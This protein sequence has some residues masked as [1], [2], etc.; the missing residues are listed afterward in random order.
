MDCS[1]EAKASAAHDSLMRVK[2]RE[3]EYAQEALANGK[4]LQSAVQRLE[5][6]AHGLIHSSTFSSR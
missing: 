5:V 2:N 6:T 4:E 1:T 3:L